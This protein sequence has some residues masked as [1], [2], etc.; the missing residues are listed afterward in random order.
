MKDGLVTYDG[1]GDVLFIHLDYT[2]SCFQIVIVVDIVNVVVMAAPVA[3]GIVDIGEMCSADWI[4]SDRIVTN[5]RD[6]D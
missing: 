3:H 5:E 6:E 4:C 2:W 1:V